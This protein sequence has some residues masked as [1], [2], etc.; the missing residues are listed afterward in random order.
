MYKTVSEAVAKEKEKAGSSPGSQEGNA[1]SG[2]GEPGSRSWEDGRRGKSFLFFEEDVL[3]MSC[4]CSS[5][6]NRRR[7]RR[8]GVPQETL[9][10]DK[11]KERG[12]GKEAGDQLYCVGCFGGE[13]GGRLLKARR[14]DKDWQ[15]G[16]QDKHDKP[17][18]RGGGQGRTEPHEGE[19]R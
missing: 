19:A 2:E 1:R 12:R 13:E 18:Q 10:L 4:L 17:A 15:R 3:A 6:T 14:Q 8:R 16:R 11:L 9:H 5:G 7:G